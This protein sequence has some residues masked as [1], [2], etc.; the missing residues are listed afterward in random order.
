MRS[1]V[2]FVVQLP[3][4]LHGSSS[5][6]K[7][8]VESKI[9]N[10][11]FNIK[12]LPLKFAKSMEDIGA[13]S[14]MKVNKMFLYAFKLMGTLISFSPDLV[15][16]TFSP[17]GISFYRDVLYVSILK[18]FRKKILFHL[19]VKGITEQCEASKVKKALY[20]F[21]FKNTNIIC[22]STL[23]GEDLRVVYK[24]VPM[25][26][27]N[28]IVSQYREPTL[29]KIE[30]GRI[31]LLYLSNLMRAKGVFVLLDALKILKE[32]NVDFIARIVGKPADVSKEEI[33]RYLLKNQMSECVNVEDGK[34]GEDKIRAF[35]KADI[36]IHPTLNDAFPLVILEAMQFQLPVIST[37]EGS[38]PEIINEGV[39]GLLVQKN[40]SIMLADKIA[41]L[42]SNKQMREQMGKE[43][44][45][46]F[47]SSFTSDRMEHTLE[48]IMKNLIQEK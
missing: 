39:T 6:N 16:F 36:F 23:L 21:A 28:G 46:K 26:V 2:L 35:R 13:F 12:V 40:N 27:N 8:F 38:I 47:L 25:V 34:Y 10:D 17:M 11:S 4:P 30:N 24:G 41:T 31:E 3:P 5:I 45:K 15:Y 7:A 33:N 14:L 20:K 19:H 1:K 43:G 42:I 32:R 9:L 48:S 44:R 18:L 22:L 37:F 29:D